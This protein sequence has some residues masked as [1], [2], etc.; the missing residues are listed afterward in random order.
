[1]KTFKLRNNQWLLSAISI[2]VN[3]V[4][5]KSRQ[6]SKIRNNSRKHLRDPW[7]CSWLKK[8]QT[9]K[10]GQLCW[11]YQ[12]RLACRESQNWKLNKAFLHHKLCQTLKKCQVHKD[13]QLYWWMFPK[14][15]W[16]A[17][18]SDVIGRKHYSQTVRSSSLLNYSKA[19][20]SYVILV[21]C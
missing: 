3:L 13:L 9:Y 15:F 14:H 16:N 1:M 18:F 5:T 2:N 19:F 21:E 10:A 20:V 8:N 17:D 12:T 6:N 4:A 7:K 11:I